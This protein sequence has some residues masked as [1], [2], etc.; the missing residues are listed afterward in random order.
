MRR[1][2]KCFNVPHLIISSQEFNLIT[3]KDTLLRS[4]LRLVVPFATKFPFLFVKLL[5]SFLCQQ[6]PTRNQPPTLT[7]LKTSI[8][9]NK[10]TC[11]NFSPLNSIRI[12]E[13]I[14]EPDIPDH[15]ED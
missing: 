6:K 10:H 14:D 4:N 5:P 11:P 7:F 3:S 8:S 12:I 1:N 15:S 9:N 2:S 13:P